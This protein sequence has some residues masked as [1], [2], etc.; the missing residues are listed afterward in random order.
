MMDV[1]RVLMICIVTYGCS[2]VVGSVFACGKRGAEKLV[3]SVAAGFSVLWAGFLV[4]CV[5]MILRRMYFADVY[6]VYL[7]FCL[8][9]FV[10]G[11]IV[12]IRRIILGKKAVSAA[13]KSSFEK[14]GDIR[15]ILKQ[16]VF[17]SE[18][19]RALLLWMLFFV[20]LL[21][22]LILVFF[23]A[24]EEGDDA[25]YVAVTTFSKD[26]GRL[27]TNSAYMGNYVGLD[28]R[29]A[30]APFP[31]WVAVLAQLS[32]LSGAAA[33]HV[34][35]PLIMI[36][37][38]YGLYYLFG[39]KLFVKENDTKWKLPLFLCFAELLVLFGGYSSYAAENFLLVRAGQGKAVLANGIIL[40]LLYLLLECMERLE[41]KEAPGFVLWCLI[42]LTV[43]AGCLCS[44]QGSLLLCILLGCAALCGAAVYKRWLLLVQMLACIPV[45]LVVAGLYYVFS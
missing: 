8:V 34:V 27:Y 6:R 42:F 26:M 35:L 21:L 11:S 24:Y 45:P 16:N 31:V 5:P 33:S 10:T 25:F 29:H 19:G 1:I 15:R 18:E 41:R 23:L 20:F 43:S 28:A 7:A 13:G 36:P 3:F 12:W 32:G 9:A 22:Q 30:L 40:L 39:R 4:I 44:T 2:A 38:T 17:K 14:S 37:L